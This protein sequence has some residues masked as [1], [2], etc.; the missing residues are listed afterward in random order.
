MN[1]QVREEILRRK[2]ELGVDR[3]EE[4]PQELIV[5]EPATDKRGQSLPPGG[6]TRDVHPRDLKLKLLDLETEEEQRDADGVALV[7]QKYSKL[8]KFLFGKYSMTRTKF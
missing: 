5:Y 2:V 6:V 4:V 7:L 1:K 8:L 3:G